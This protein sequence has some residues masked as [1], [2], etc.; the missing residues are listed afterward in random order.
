MA[1]EVR[2]LAANLED[3][4]LP[5]VKICR[6]NNA[7]FFRW[8]WRI[9]LLQQSNNDCRTRVDPN[10]TVSTIAG[11]LNLR[12][13]VLVL[14]FLNMFQCAMQSHHA[15]IHTLPPRP[16]PPHTTNFF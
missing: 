7:V 14:A 11:L 10:E 16:S 6:C 4:F 3:L 1:D 8:Q 12:F 2:F 13:H 9:R 15:P 5:H